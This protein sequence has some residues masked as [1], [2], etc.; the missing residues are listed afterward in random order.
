VLVDAT[1]RLMQI[2]HSDEVLVAGDLEIRPA[3]WL[4][5]ADG[6]VLMLTIRE[7]EVL[8]ALVRRQG[9]VASRR[10][11]YEAVWAQPLRA[12][13]RTIDV[14]VRRLR[15]K[16]EAALPGWA[17]IHTHFGL[18]YRF[19]PERRGLHPFHKTATAP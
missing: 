15:V 8:L 17:F 7:F 14:Y 13:D 16:L 10:E 19:T 9:C 11:L 5:L 2:V 1:L 4:A 12:G 3:N 6:R 18:G